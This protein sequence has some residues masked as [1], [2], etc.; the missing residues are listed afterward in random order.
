MPDT[1]AAKETVKKAAKAAKAEASRAAAAASIPE[2]FREM[3]EKGVEQAKQNYTRIRNAAE[4]ATDLA[5]D[6]Y[7]T[8]AR[9]AAEFNLKAI[10]ALRTNV[11]ASF[12]YA[13]ELLGAK[14]F[15]EAL[16]LSATHMR[17]QFETLADQAKEFSALAQKVATETSEPLKAGMTRNSPLH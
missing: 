5:E 4:E 3:A 16:E 15:S 14:S 6:T 17:Q 9:G 7:L 12:D 11:N 8:A 2:V 13:R 10:E 1:D